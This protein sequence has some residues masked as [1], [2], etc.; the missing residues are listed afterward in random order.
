LRIPAVAL[1]CRQRIQT[2][3]RAAEPLP[4]WLHNAEEIGRQ[5]R[6]FA[7]TRLSCGQVSAS[8]TFSLESTGPPMKPSMISD[9]TT[10]VGTYWDVAT[11]GCP[12]TNAEPDLNAF[13]DE[14][15]ATRD[16]LEPFIRPSAL[17][18][19]PSP[20]STKLTSSSRS[21][22]AASKTTP[23]PCAIPEIARITDDERAVR[24]RSRRQCD[25]LVERTVRNVH[26]QLP[27]GTPID[28]SAERARR[29]SHGGRNTVEPA[30]GALERRDHVPARELAERFR[31]CRPDVAYV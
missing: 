9:A 11:C 19:G 1:W 27:S 13:F 17:L 30:L 24:R 31:R 18:S 4:E 29:R 3:V 6:A 7:R 22:S 21:C 15:E 8:G 5:E 26:A 14:N 25:Q 12:L 10:A 23:K 20:T 28:V 16:R 2:V